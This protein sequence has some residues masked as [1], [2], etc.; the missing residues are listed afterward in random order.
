MTTTVVA[1]PRAEVVAAGRRT[2]LV[3]VPVLVPA[4][5]LALPRGVEPDLDGASVT[6]TSATGG[7]V[8]VAGPDGAG[9]VDG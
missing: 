3:P 4:L 5:T 2:V 1:V 6:G 8:V 7:S 9:P